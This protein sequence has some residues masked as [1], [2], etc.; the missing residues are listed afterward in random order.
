MGEYMSGNQ[1]A[2]Q[3]AMNLGHSAAW[4]Q[5]WEQA[6]SYYRQA[7]EEA[8]DNP[9]ALS[10]LALALFE[11]QQ[12]DEALRYYQRGSRVA[13]ND[14]VS[15]EKMARIYERQGKL[16]EAVQSGCQAAELQ[17]RA[18]EVQKAVENWLAVLRL[19]PENLL[20]RTRLGM[21]YERV[22][23]KLEATSEYLAAASVVQHSGDPGK[24]M[25]LA[26]H[27]LQ[28]LPESGDARR[29]IM[30]IRNGQVLPRPGAPKQREGSAQLPAP[31]PRN[32]Q[33]EEEPAGLDP[34]GEARQEAMVQLAAILFDQVEDSGSAQPQKR[35]L[36]ALT[37]GLPGFGDEE[38]DRTRILLHLSQA[39]ESLSREQDNQAA[40]ELE[41]A[42]EAGLSHPAAMF[43][44][45]ALETGRDPQKALRLLQQS[46][47][48]PDF[49]L[50]SYLLLGKNY[51]AQ[52]AL[53]EAAMATLEA[54]RLADMATVPE[55][56]R[57]EMEQLYEPLIENQTQPGNEAG[58]RNICETVSSQLARPGWR[59]YL[60]TARQQLPAEGA[61][62]APV[63]LAEMLLESRSSQVVEMLS[64]VKKLAAQNKH[65]TAME[66]AYYALQFAPTYLPLH[67]QIGELLVQ[68]GHTQAAMSKFLTVSSLY[69]LRGEAGNAIRLLTRAMQIS[70]LDT[71][72]RMALIELLSAQG[73]VDEAVQQYINL[74]DFYYQMSDLDKAR[75]TYLAALRLSQSGRGSKAMSV[76]V[77]QK[78]ADI[79][80]QRLDLRGA[81]KL[82]EQIRGLQPEDA[83]A[84]ASV[85][86]LNLRLN[87]DEAALNEMDAYTGYLESQNG[88]DKAIAFVETIVK[89]RPERLDVRKRLAD[90]YLR[91]GQQQKA[92]EQLDL[93]A[94][95]LLVAKNKQGAAAILEKIIAIN[96]PNA[97]EYRAALAQLRA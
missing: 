41:S 36:A 70:P 10:S 35:G 29:A 91:A 59:K 89:E 94:D 67:V 14:P 23:R 45:G 42:E 77:L 48:H 52:G 57:E 73:R 1:E 33:P 44:T 81:L 9:A 54:L 13:P 31:A 79:D 12:Y 90:L 32:T 76:L 61:G 3:K 34:V 58:L 19:Q 8:P 51:A 68:E 25:Q 15:L 72:I 96:P 55:E 78:A 83:A 88:R 80:Q 26:E 5:Q 82:F 87:Q 65:R 27:A 43:L 66:E 21:V 93:I 40:A 95:G 20:A 17:L 97:A 2:Y 24:A 50:A 64:Q 47:K 56:Q 75:Q 53:R 30:M 63:P 6:A 86:N 69:N 85:I 49:A 38:A 16:V 22:G 92:V 62:G 7:L 84:R 18:Q 28:V 71:S 11:M 37:R 60:V 39:I 74:G 4:D 46:V